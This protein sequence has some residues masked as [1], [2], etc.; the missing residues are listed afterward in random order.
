MSPMLI[1]ARSAGRPSITGTCRMRR[2]V[3]STMRSLTWSPGSAVRTSLVMIAA[4]V[5]ESTVSSSSR[6][7]Y[8]V[9]LGDDAVDRRP[10]AADD[11][12]ADVVLGEQSDQV[13][14]SR[15]GL[16]VTT[17]ASLRGDHVPDQHL[18][19]RP[20][21]LRASNLSRKPAKRIRCWGA[22]VSPRVRPPVRA[23]A[24]TEVVH[25]SAASQP[26][27][28]VVALDGA[29][30][31]ERRVM[32]DAVAGQDVA[33]VGSVNPVERGEP[34]AGFA[35]DDVKGSHVVELELWLRSKVD[36]ALGHEHVGPEVAVRPSA[37]APTGQGEEV[38]EPTALLPATQA[39]VRQRRIVEALKSETRQG[40]AFI[41]DL[42]V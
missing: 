32:Q 11:E 26:P 7:A 41:S 9:A 6:R 30:E 40:V 13:A 20:V 1:D 36:R 5:A 19:S 25:G 23:P 3:I 38:V 39:R 17:S 28:V 16:I 8:D 10:S 31:A 15:V 37:P 21:P 35:H 4:T 2:S 29:D 33:A 27:R 14:H 12:G 24:G 18:T 34:A 42:P 22:R